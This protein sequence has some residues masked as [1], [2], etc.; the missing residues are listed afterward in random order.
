MIND[1]IGCKCIN[2]GAMRI[3]RL[4]MKTAISTYGDVISKIG[5]FEPQ[6]PAIVSLNSESIKFR[7]LL[8]ELDNTPT[9]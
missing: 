8:E 9:C 1:M 7:K 2:V 5:K 6:S 3:L 4:G